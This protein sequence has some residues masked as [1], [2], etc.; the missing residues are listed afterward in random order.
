MKRFTIDLEGPLHGLDFG[1]NG[2]LVILVHGL[3]GSSI[4]WAA[5]GSEFT[6]HGHVIALD[7][8]GFGRTPPAGRTAAI[9]DQAALLAAYIEQ[10]GDEPALVIGNSM[11]GIISMLLAAR[12]PHLVDRLIL[13]NPAAPSWDPSSINRGWAIM[14]GVYL[15]PGVN[16]AAFTALQKRGTP[17]LRTAESMNMIAASGDRVP[18]W[19][20]QLHADVARE[21]DNMPW[22]SEAFLQAYKSI[23][24]RLVPPSRYDR[25]VHRITAPTLLIHGTLDV[26]VP[27]SAAVRLADQRPDWSFVTLEDTGHVPQMEAAETLVKV[28]ARFAEQHHT[29]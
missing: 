28:V 17:D 16:K 2:R 9:D 29:V 20:T 24:K 11:G 12:H 19:L 7:L 10:H 14:M 22:T 25:I 6:T 26:I 27:Y 13:V 8:P 1:G 15:L 21:R 3:G 18:E 5:V 23:V 4:N